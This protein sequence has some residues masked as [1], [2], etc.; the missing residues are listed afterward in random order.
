VFCLNC[1][2]PSRKS[3]AFSDM[4][5]N[6]PDHK[7]DKN[8]DPSVVQP[9]DLLASKFNLNYINIFKIKNTFFFF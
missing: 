3:D 6:I 7:I 5:L 4:S 2:K 8:A 1:K 9:V